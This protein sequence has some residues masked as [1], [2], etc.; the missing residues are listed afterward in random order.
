A[1]S[2]PDLARTVGMQPPSSYSYFASKNAI[3]NATYAQGAQQ[4]VDEQRSSMPTP[5]LIAKV[6]DIGP[7]AARWRATRPALFRRMP[8]KEEVGGQVEIWRMG[9]LLD[10]ILTRDPWM[11]RVDVVHA[12]GREMELTLEPRVAAS[13]GD[14]RRC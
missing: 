6:D 14:V 1:L 13:D 3:Y 9:Y 12:T 2:L 4:F 5:K 8:M 7:R 10:V 11:H